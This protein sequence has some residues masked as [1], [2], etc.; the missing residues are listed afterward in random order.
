MKLTE[1]AND[2]LD[3]LLDAF[4]SGDI[5]DAITHTVIQ[6]HNVPMAS[7]SFHNQILIYLSGATDARGFRQWQE[8]NHHVTKGSKALYILVP[9]KG[10]RTES[11]VGDSGEE[12][13]VNYVYGFKAAPVFRA[14][15]TDGEALP[16]QEPLEPT[17]PPPLVEVAE[18]WGIPLSYVPFRQAVVRYVSVRLLRR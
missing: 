12:K 11:P 15:D 7:W 5:T 4:E 14:E 9:L 2:Q 3:A 13:E 18:G 6:G 10:K 1:K 16:E 8:V 17:E